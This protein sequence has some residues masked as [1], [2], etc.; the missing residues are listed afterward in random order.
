MNKR[1]FIGSFIPA[2]KLI[3][4]FENIRKNFDKVSKIKWTRTTDN[5]HITY[6]FLGETTENHIFEIDKF[7]SKIFPSNIEINIQ[8]K[9]LSYFKRKNKPSVLYANV[10]DNSNKLKEIHKQLVDFLFDRGIIQSKTTRFNPHITLGRIK[11]VDNDFYKE[12][13][14][15]NNIKFDEINDIKIEIIESI[16]SPQG[17]LYKSVK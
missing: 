13:E 8:V 17:A 12:I 10:I 6:I 2:K 3:I 11:N 1:I 4:D 5:F 15:Y 14:K 9:S 16:L 7:I